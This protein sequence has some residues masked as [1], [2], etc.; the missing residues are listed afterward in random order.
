MIPKRLSLLVVAALLLCAALSQSQVKPNPKY[1]EMVNAFALGLEQ[2]GLE[3]CLE[4][5]TK[6]E[7]K[8]VRPDAIFFI[9]EYF[10]SNALQPNGTT[11]QLLQAYTYYILYDQDYPNAEYSSTVK[12]RIESIRGLAE[13]NVVL[14][15]LID[16]LNGERSIVTKKLEAASLFI[17]IK[18]PN[19]LEFFLKAEF[20]ESPVDMAD[21]YFDDIIVSHPL[22]EVYAYYLKIV[23]KLDPFADKPFL[24]VTF[25]DYSRPSVSP[26]PYSSASYAEYTRRRPEL[27][28]LM[29][30]MSV[31]YPS[32]P[33][34]LNLHL[35]MARIFM[36]KSSGRY[37]S[38]TARHLNFILKND[39]DKLGVR[40]TLAKEFVLNNRFQE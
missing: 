10:F 39:Q 15:S 31:K 35:I 21:K 26:T 22:F 13:T 23:M 27:D 37:D 38:E 24:K 2:K 30:T 29:N 16:R 18:P 7:Y 14:G 1:S 25:I 34:T 12:K 9:A 8:P 36:H 17:N 4:L 5:I 40:Y 28:S 20:E 3:S 19:P 32:H 6:D 11:H 33:L